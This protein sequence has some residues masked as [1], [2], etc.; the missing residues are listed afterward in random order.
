[1]REI[2]FRGMDLLKCEWWMGYYIFSEKLNKH[3]ITQDANCLPERS[4]P[5]N[6]AHWAEVKPETVGQFTGLTDKN[7]VEIY[8]GD[9]VVYD[10]QPSEKRAWKLTYYG[11]ITWKSTG[12]HIQP[13]KPKN[14]GG[15]NGWLISLPGAY[16]GV[17]EKLFEVIGNIHEGV[18]E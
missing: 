14:N 8:E 17:C 3:F 6:L 12:F 4:F 18:K 16:K 7:G 15:Y 5:V 13:Y 1:M 10:Y 9:V 11:I 2:K